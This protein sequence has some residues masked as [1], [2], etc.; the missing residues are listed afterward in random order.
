M[1]SRKIEYLLLAFVFLITVGLRLYYVWIYKELP[2]VEL[3]PQDTKGFKELAS[4][5]V[6]GNF[7]HEHFPY[8]NSLY[9]LFL[10]LIYSVFGDA[11]LTVMIVQCVLEGVNGLLIFF[12]GRHVFGRVVAWMSV[13]AY[14]V[15]GLALFYS[16]MLLATTLLI[17]LML[18]FLG[19]L[20]W[21]E[22]KKW[23]ALNLLAGLLFGLAFMGRPNL[24]LF[25]P[26]LGLWFLK[27]IR[28][29][30]VWPSILKQGGCFAAGLAVV[31][32]LLSF[33]NYQLTE[34]FSPFSSHGGVNFYIGNNPLSDGFFMEIEGVS[35]EPVKQVLTSIQVAE[36]ALG[37]SLTPS[38]A[39][40]Y[41]LH[42]GLDFWKEHPRHAMGLQ[43]LKT[44]LFFR[45][46]ELAL[47][48]DYDF[49][50]E[51]VGILSWPWLSFGVVS[52]LALLGLLLAL[53]RERFKGLSLLW[54]FAL[55][56]SGAVILFFVSDRYRLPVVPLFI[57]FGAFAI[58]R[59][60]QLA[61]EKRFRFLGIA[62]L[63][64]SVLA[65]A[66]NIKVERFDYYE[67]AEDHYR[68]AN[69]MT[70]REMWEE[71]AEEY[72]R[73][74]TIEPM[75]RDA[76]YNLGILRAKQRRYLD[77]IKLWLYTLDIAP[78]FNKCW[79]SIHQAEEAF[80]SERGD[81][82]LSDRLLELAAFYFESGKLE[83]SEHFFFRALDLAPEHVGAHYNLGIVY[84][85]QNR[86]EEAIGKWQ[87]VLSIV[88]EHE[89]AMQSI[90]RAR[91]MLSG[92]E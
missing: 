52:P 40:K 44:A 36:A 55:T 92:G 17:F 6:E 80:L 1:S 67:M 74:L 47:N 23:P 5:L 69:I 4:A 38:Q 46:E 68:L 43:V 62:L 11:D 61:R 41:W 88:P 64:G 76:A 84:A 16:A 9:P 2:I 14:A 42:R 60:F 90:E 25:L 70:E 29:P 13:V 75:H 87:D 8:V 32:S 81:T 10:A 31:L 34:R 78:D 71:A 72:D 45:A 24:V 22:H 82:L 56:Y 53:D 19:T 63:G 77:A 85:T 51:Y 50:R 65:L 7:Y 86:L 18:S 89:E 37:E 39:S 33:R 30:G 66:V 28:Q 20:L 27:N 3:L 91:G 58:C 83:A 48:I 73:A 12:I 26:V 49:N 35:N 21:A 59:M 57:L 79:D 15:Y 54:L